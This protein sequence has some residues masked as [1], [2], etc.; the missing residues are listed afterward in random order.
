[1]GESRQFGAP[2]SMGLDEEAPDRVLGGNARVL[3]RLEGA[4][5]TGR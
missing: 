1:M 2:Y 5:E 3:F 4:G